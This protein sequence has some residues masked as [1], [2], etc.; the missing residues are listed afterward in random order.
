MTRPCED[1]PGER[2]P[3]IIR[4]NKL[5]ALLFATMMLVTAGAASAQTLP[6]GKWAIDGNGFAG[7]LNITSVDAQGNLQGTVFGQGIIGFWDEASQKITFMRITDALNVTTFQIY[8][9]FLFNDNNNPNHYW[10]TGYFEAFQGTGAV[11]Q[12]V[13]YGWFAD[14]F[15]I[16]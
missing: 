1:D 12:R 13:L 2:M 11:A 9:G 16:Q 8:T 15:P 6:K 10:L 14:T 5:K 7:Q 3:G 4:R